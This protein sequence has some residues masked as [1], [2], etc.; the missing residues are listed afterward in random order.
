MHIAVLIERYQPTG[1]GAERSTAQIVDRLLDRGHRV[2]VLAGS[3]D[4]ADPRDGLGIETCADRR[5]SS[6]LHYW[7]MV[8]WARERLAT[9]MFDTSV[10]MSTSFPAKFVQPRAGMVRMI[11]NQ[12]IARRTTPAKRLSKRLR[13]AVTLKQ[14]LLLRAEQQTMRDPGVY[15]FIA[16]SEFIAEQLCDLYG[17]D[18]ARIELIRNG[19]ALLPPESP[20]NDRPDADLRTGLGIEPDATIF[21]FP[22]NDPHRK[23][24]DPLLNAVA[25]L[26]ERGVDA[27]VLM[28]GHYTFKLNR[29]AGR[30]GVR[31]NVRWLGSSRH[32]AELYAAADATV[33]PSF[34]DPSSKVVIESLMMGTP[35]ITTV[36]NGASDFVINP[37]G[38]DR[39]VVLPDPDDHAALADAMQAMCDPARRAA[40]S[41]AIAPIAHELT[42][43]RHVNQ[44][45]Q[46]LAA[47]LNP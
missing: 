44:L 36:F 16:I 39:G 5:S 21:L 2:T 30:L 20:I 42:M 37:T 4:A 46:L 3:S 28:V 10:S 19:S 31:D 34:Y 1:G 25:L 41:A 15:R 45:E 27:V 26:R 7:K 17:I 47:S 11:H 22:A 12:T 40:C 35:A 13:V 32:L 9:G 33:L 18:R 38:E 6:P 24:I 23:G 43:D 29:L 8:R 14:R